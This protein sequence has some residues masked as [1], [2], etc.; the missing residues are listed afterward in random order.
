MAVPKVNCPDSARLVKAYRACPPFS[1]AV[2]RG[3]ALPP[4]KPL[5]VF[6]MRLPLVTFKLR[7]EM[8]F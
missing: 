6:D 8:F 3:T 4:V 7:I 1:Q 2:A 5:I